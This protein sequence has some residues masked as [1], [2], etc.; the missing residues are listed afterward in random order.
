MAIDKKL[1]KVVPWTKFRAAM[2]ARRYVRHCP[3]EP[4]ITLSFPVRENKHSD[5]QSSE[6]RDQRSPQPQSFPASV[7]KSRFPEQPLA[8]VL[9][10]SAVAPARIP[11]LTRSWVPKDIPI[12]GYSQPRNGLQR[13]LRSSP[14]T[15]KRKSKPPTPAALVVRDRLAENL[16]LIMD[17]QFPVAKYRTKSGRQRAM[18]QKVGYTWSTI[19]RILNREV[20]TTVDTIAELSLRLGISPTD[21]LAPN[22]SASHLIPSPPPR[23]RLIGHE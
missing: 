18:A 15:R 12:H 8:T 16:Q 3:T 20:G 17:E 4:C 9:C 21:L 14:M 5:A 13:G 6:H 7:S 10:T 2:R 19:Q 22:F 1:R 11:A 23:P